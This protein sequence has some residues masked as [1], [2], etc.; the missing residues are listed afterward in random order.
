MEWQSGKNRWRYTDETKLVIEIQLTQGRTTLIDAEDFEKVE[1]YIWCVSKYATNTY[2]THTLHTQTQHCT[3]RMHR[4]IV[5]LENGDKRVVDH[6]DGDGLNNVR[7]NIRVTTASGNN[8]NVR[9]RRDNTTG[10]TG[11]FEDRRRPKFYVTFGSAESGNK[12]QSSFMFGGKRTRE[13]A[14]A[15]AIAKRKE[16]VEGTNCLNGKRPKLSENEE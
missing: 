15:L 16:W 12:K 11:V 7:S 6:R 14:L 8:N 4:L 3:I 5:D 1:K 2:A 10:C 9:M 13:E